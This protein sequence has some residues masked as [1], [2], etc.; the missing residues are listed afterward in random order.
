MT[1]LRIAGVIDKPTSLAMIAVLKVDCRQTHIDLNA[2]FA[3]R[4]GHYGTF[5]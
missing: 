4:P 2:I 1:G 3:I 5:C